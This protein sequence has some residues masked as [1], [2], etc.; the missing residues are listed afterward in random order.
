MKQLITLFLCLW[1]IAAFSQQRTPYNQ[2]YLQPVLINPAFTG[3][4]GV[5][6]IFLN[7]RVQW[8][9]IEDAPVTT[10]AILQLPVTERISLGFELYKDRH[11]SVLSSNEI[12]VNGAY[13]LYFD[14]NGRNFLTFG[15]SLG[16]GKNMIEFDGTDQAIMNAQDRSFYFNGRFGTA[17]HI[18]KATFGLSLPQLMD[19]DILNEKNFENLGIEATK[20]SI[21][22]GSYRVNLSPVFDFEPTALYRIDKYGNNQW[23]GL[24]I[25]YY[26]SMIWAG[27]GYRQDYGAIGHFGL[28]VKQ[29]LR[30]GYSYEFAP[31]QATGIGNGSHE[32][33]V[34]YTFG[35]KSQKRM[36]KQIISSGEPKAVPMQPFV[37]QENKKEREGVVTTT[38]PAATAAPVATGTAERISQETTET[39]AVV[40]EEV[41]DPVVQIEEKQPVKEIKWLEVDESREVSSLPKGCYL[42]VGAFQQSANAIRYQDEVSRLGYRAVVA[43]DEAT[44]FN[45]VYINRAD[46]PKYL[47]AQRDAVRKKQILYFPEAWI[48]EIR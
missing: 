41:K 2:Y 48:L 6:S 17:V 4:S 18:G 47:H 23:E 21:L 43:Y 44:K 29:M 36:P 12:K 34:T 25:V 26:K 19:T 27:A 31:E 35:K 14:H 39:V 10:T 8:S 9:G 11:S 46:E 30:I 1:C 42:V 5:S 7:H 32:F 20:Q 38:V 24:G 16:V 45:Y 28:A 40:T 3:E 13:T 33:Q 15:L 37:K 22:H